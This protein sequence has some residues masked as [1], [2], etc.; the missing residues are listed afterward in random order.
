MGAMPANHT[1]GCGTHPQRLC[2]APCAPVSL[3]IRRVF[4]RLA[5]K[6]LAHDRN[7]PGLPTSLESHLL[8][9]FKIQR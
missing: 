9:A 7:N 3:L 1:D 2:H 5:E 6:V 4:F 8:D